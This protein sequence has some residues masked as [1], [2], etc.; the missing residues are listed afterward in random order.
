MRALVLSALLGLGLT[1]STPTSA[2]PS[3]AAPQPVVKRKAKTRIEFAVTP[4]SVVIF[5]DGERLGAAADVGVVPAKPGRR[6]VRLERGEDTTEMEVI[7][8][9]GKKLRF[10]YEFE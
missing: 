8:A 3:G 10:A 6:V 1:A 4:A 2:A 5:L 7:L 9:R